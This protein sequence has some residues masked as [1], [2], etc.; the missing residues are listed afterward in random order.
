MHTIIYNYHHDFFLSLVVCLINYMPIGF[1]RCY[2]LVHIHTHTHT[3]VKMCR[4]FAKS[5][6]KEGLL[7]TRGRE[8]NLPSQSQRLCVVSDTPL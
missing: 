3:G 4:F 5:G 8:A 6:D 1:R 2:L 7:V